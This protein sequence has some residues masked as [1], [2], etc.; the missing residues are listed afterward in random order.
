MRE[1][2]VVEEGRP[3]NS[4]SE[5]GPSLRQD[6]P[7]SEITVFPVLNQARL[8]CIFHHLQH[9]PSRDFLKTGPSPFTS[10]LFFPP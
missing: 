4:G 5:T 6:P 2:P 1:K 7:L 3:E 8:H 10:L 9:I